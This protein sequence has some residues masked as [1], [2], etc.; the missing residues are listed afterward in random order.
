M[1]RKTGDSHQA[2][3]RQVGG[4]KLGEDHHDGLRAGH[5]GMKHYIKMELGTK[6]RVAR[7]LLVGF[8]WKNV[9]SKAYVVTELRS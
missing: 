4:G 2:G 6:L 7:P 9:H 8:L 3:D 5:Y 1:L